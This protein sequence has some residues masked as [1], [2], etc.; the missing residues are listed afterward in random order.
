MKRNEGSAPGERAAWIGVR[1]ATSALG[2]CALLG[3]ACE[4]TSS[5]AGTSTALTVE[6]GPAWVMVVPQGGSTAGLNH[7]TQLRNNTGSSMDWS[8]QAD[9]P[10]IQC[11]PA[12]GTLGASQQTVSQVSFEAASFS[13]LQPGQHT[14]LVTFQQVGGPGSALLRVDVSVT[15]GSA[16][17]TVTPAGNLAATGP[18]GG[19]FTGL[20]KTYDLTAGASAPV[21]WYAT[22]TVPWVV[23][24]GASS[25]TLPASGQTP[26]QVSIDA[27]QANAMAPGNYSGTLEV[28]ETASNVLFGSRQV[29]LDV[30]APPAPSGFTTFTPSVDTRTVHVSSTLGNDSFDGLTPGTPKKT[31]S[32]GVALLRTDSPT[33]CC[34]GRATPGPTRTSA[35]GRSRVAPPPSRC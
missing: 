21:D 9:V 3:A 14:G 18:Q 20:S 25:G 13:S 33:G 30:S 19:P 6:N 12:S 2:A 23:F 31:L 8:A 29:T 11:A 4:T 1:I 22:V 35:N 5:D 10:W 7:D 17:L 26:L 16:Q 27:A 34:S 15:P 28:R 24:P 32:A